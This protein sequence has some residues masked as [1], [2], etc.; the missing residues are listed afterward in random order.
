MNIKDNEIVLEYGSIELDLDFGDYSRAPTVEWF[1][2]FK[3]EDADVLEDTIYVYTF[4][5]TLQEAFKWYEEQVVKC[6][7][8]D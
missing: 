6:V 8:S 1:V 4:K 7:K 5:D 2:E 3:Y